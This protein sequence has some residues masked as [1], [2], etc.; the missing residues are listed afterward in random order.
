MQYPI[1]GNFN[2]VAGQL[3]PDHICDDLYMQ[4]MARTT[5]S[6][7]VG[8][9]DKPVLK[10]TV[11]S[12]EGLAFEVPRLYAIDWQNPIIDGQI[13]DGFE[14]QQ[15]VESIMVTMTQY[16]W[17]IKN[18]DLELMNVGT[19]LQ[20]KVLADALPQIRDASSKHFDDS[21]L[22]AATTQTYN[23][24]GVYQNGVMPITE[25][26]VV[27]D[28]EMIVYTYAGGAT[29]PA[30]I[31]GL[32]GGAFDYTTKASVANIKACVDKAL[33][34]SPAA[35]GIK[36]YNVSMLHGQLNP[37]YIK[38]MS[39]AAV[40]QLEL[41][42]NFI[43]PF[44]AR[45]LALQDQPSPVNGAF[46]V[47]KIDAAYIF[48]CPDLDRY[49]IVINGHTYSWNLMFGV[50]AWAVGWGLFPKIVTVEDMRELK[51]GI[52]SHEIRGLQSLR[53]PSLNNAAILAEQGIIHSFT[54]D[55]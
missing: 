25:R 13:K 27:G 1:I 38:L 44:T 47:G 42:P 2:G 35:D 3:F 12:G 51:R 5:F 46:F 26:A 15:R 6:E 18:T 39:S 41:D 19:P 24:T 11:K 17:A 49:K 37:S 52:Y 4:W 23:Q 7:W 45:G 28:N 36:P 10:K 8:G 34:T 31:E 21:L 22:K 16:T 20:P 14:Q 54:R 32:A 43:T 30:T 29:L 53:Y 48:R 33:V 9:T 40:R 55:S 50:G